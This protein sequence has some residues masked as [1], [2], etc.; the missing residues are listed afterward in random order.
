MLDILIQF[1]NS[2]PLFVGLSSMFMAYGSRSMM[3][4]VPINVEKMFNKPFFRRLFIFFAVFLAF[5]DVKK[6]IFITLLF[7]IIFNYLLNDQS[8]VY[9]GNYIGL[10]KEEEPLDKKVVTAA[11]IENAK[12]IIQIYNQNLDDNKI[13]PTKL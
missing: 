2:N 5:R 11:D 3:A 12:R 13:N 4:E 1:I 10:K 8:K 6:A 7:I 9:I